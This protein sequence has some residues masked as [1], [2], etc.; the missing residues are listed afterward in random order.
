MITLKNFKHL[1]TISTETDFVLFGANY[2]SNYSGVTF[3][4]WFALP[5]IFVEKSIPETLS[6]KVEFGEIEGKHSDVYEDSTTKEESFLQTISTLKQLDDD[7]EKIK[8]QNIV[9][10]FDEFCD[11]DDCD[12]FTDFTKEQLELFDEI[13]ELQELLH[14]YSTNKLVTLTITIPE[15]EVLIFKEMMKKHP[16][17]KIEE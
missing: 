1:G 16:N 13:I 11:S 7:I 9:P 6:Y 8:F 3:S 12:T 15:E 10:F 4:S 2:D 17:W 5:Q 14:N